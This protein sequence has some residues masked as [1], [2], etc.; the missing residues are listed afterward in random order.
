MEPL[1][2]SQP[3]SNRHELAGD[4]VDELAGDVVDELA[5]DMVDE[6]DRDDRD[7]VDELDGDESERDMDV[8]EPEQS[9]NTSLTALR[10][11]VNEAHPHL[12]FDKLCISPYKV[13]LDAEGAIAS[14]KRSWKLTYPVL[15]FMMNGQLY[16]EYFHITSM[17]GLYI[18]LA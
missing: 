15:S 8:D 16:A 3:A 17:L 13:K 10:K 2:P 5:G 14:S 9:S 4:V 11:L 18:I 7:V 1:L 6:L 12:C